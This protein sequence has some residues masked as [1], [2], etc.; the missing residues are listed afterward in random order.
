MVTIKL[1]EN[2]DGDILALLQ[3][4]IDAAAERQAKHEKV[5]DETREALRLIDIEPNVVDG[6]Y[7][8]I[9]TDGREFHI[10]VNNV[11]EKP[12]FFDLTGPCPICG[13]ALLSEEMEL[14]RKNIL[15]ALENPQTTLHECRSTR[16]RFVDGT[17]LPI[18]K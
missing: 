7:A 13:Q 11:G 4:E 15:T 8:Y 10:F 6:A 12:R 14:N 2:F 17:L 18:L 1:H 5:S 3:A 9:N 16:Q